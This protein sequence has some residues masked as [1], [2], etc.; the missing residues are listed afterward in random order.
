MASPTAPWLAPCC[1]GCAQA[2][3]AGAVGAASAAGDAVST[4]LPPAIG[5]LLGYALAALVTNKRS[6][7]LAVAAGVAG[8]MLLGEF[9]R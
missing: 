9:G 6:T 1:A 4:V 3:E 8:V 5:G 2:S 7:R